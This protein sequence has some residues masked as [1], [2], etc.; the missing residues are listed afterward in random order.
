MPTYGFSSA[1]TVKF[2]YKDIPDVR[3]RLLNLAAQTVYDAFSELNWKCVWVD[4]VSKIYGSAEQP[5][6]S[7]LG[8]FFR[9]KVDPLVAPSDFTL[10]A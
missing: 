8:E 2:W 10:C 7:K 1:F 3:V 6:E 9:T 5:H 4:D